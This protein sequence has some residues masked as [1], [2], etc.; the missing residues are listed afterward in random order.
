MYTCKLK[1]N[2]ESASLNISWYSVTI[3]DVCIFM[4]KRGHPE[5]S[6][7][8]SEGCNELETK[9]RLSILVSIL[10]IFNCQIARELKH[11]SY[12]LF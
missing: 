5:T 10:N 11:S 12:R 6:G 3:I 2:Y 1:V 8:E 7:R 9:P 4:R